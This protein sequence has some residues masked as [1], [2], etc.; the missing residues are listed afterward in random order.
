MATGPVLWGGTGTSCQH[1]FFQALH[2][3]TDTVPVE[4]IGVLRPAH[5]YPDSHGATGQSA[6]AGRGHGQRRG[7]RRS[8]S[9]RY[10][11][12]RPSTLILLDEL[13]PYSFGMLLAMYEH[14]V[15]VLAKI[16]GINAFDQW[17]VQLGKRSPTS[18]CRRWPEAATPRTR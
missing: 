18:Y 6:R 3:G 11:G 1:S 5:R 17:G 10:P 12:N 14:S 7:Q 2:Q 16:W 4:F 13:T 8:R 15:F 9:R